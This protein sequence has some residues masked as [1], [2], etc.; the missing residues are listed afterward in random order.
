M[1]KTD[2]DRSYQDFIP[3]SGYASTEDWPGI[4]AFAGPTTAPSGSNGSTLGMLDQL[5][6][7]SHSTP[8]SKLPRKTH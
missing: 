6:G 3:G 2:A 8:M 7:E 5:M 4:D 1:P